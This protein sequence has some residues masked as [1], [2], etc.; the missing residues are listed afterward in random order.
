MSGG[1]GVSPR[2]TELQPSDD[3]ETLI[4][5]D[6]VGATLTTTRQ[7]VEAWREGLLDGFSILANGEGCTYLR[8]RL[9]AESSRELRLAVH[10]NLCEGPPT[11]DSGTVPLLLDERGLLARGFVGS[12]LRSCSRQRRTFLRQVETEWRAQIR[13]V[14]RIAGDRPIRALD[15]HRHVHMLPSLFPV[16]ARLAREER[17]PEIR[18]AQ[19][20]PYLSP[21]LA[22][23]LSPAFFGN[24]LKHLILRLCSVPARQAARSQNLRHPSAM[25]G[26]LYTGR[27]SRHTAESGLEAAR[28]K[29]LAVVEVVF[30]VGRATREEA[31]RWVSAPGL[32]RFYRHPNRDREYRELRKLRLG[33]GRLQG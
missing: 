10:L 18:I 23:S 15:G 21:I 11:S 6:D 2:R 19:E 28:S 16:A 17:I 26:I 5:S 20:V 1:K 12:L 22:D 29:G 27:M 4:T 24:I 3:M 9:A 30:H 14:R 25:V 32:F 13:A 8:K 31:G 33:V 7:A